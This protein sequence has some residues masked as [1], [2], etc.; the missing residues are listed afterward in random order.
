MIKYAYETLAILIPI[1]VGWTLFYLLGAFVSA[2]WSILD[3]TTQARMVCAL[4]GSV[5]AGAFWYR[6]EYLHDR[7][8]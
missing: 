3:W 7:H 2:S 8:I 1:V 4:W 6:L 5:F